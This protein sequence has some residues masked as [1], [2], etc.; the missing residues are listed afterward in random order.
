MADPPLPTSRILFGNDSNNN[1]DLPIPLPVS[2]AH[3]RSPA[4]TVVHTV[5]T[6]ATPHN[7]ETFL[8]VVV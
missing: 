2:N 7:N 3:G 1:E 5:D 4:F 8:A 6:P